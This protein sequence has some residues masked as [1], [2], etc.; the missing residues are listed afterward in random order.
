MAYKRKTTR[1]T[2]R[3]KTAAKKSKKRVGFIG[4]FKTAAKDKKYKAAKKRATD[5]VKAAA[6][7]WKDAVKKAKK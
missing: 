5:A 4:V 6:K 1:K 3:K 7:A 2:A